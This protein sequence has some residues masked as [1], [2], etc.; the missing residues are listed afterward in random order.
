MHVPIQART[1]AASHPFGRYTDEEALLDR[2]LFEHFGFPRP[3]ENMVLPERVAI[4]WRRFLM[5]K[6]V[7]LMLA[8]LVLL[9]AVS[10]SSFADGGAPPP[11]CAPGHCKAN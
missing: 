3:K 2:A 5:K 1:E 6:M 9:S 11:M 4:P 10:I 7:R 8:T